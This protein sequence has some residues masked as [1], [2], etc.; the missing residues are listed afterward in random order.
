MIALLE[1]IA[2]CSPG[3]EQNVLGFEGTEKGYAAVKG[4]KIV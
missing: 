2:A 4:C 3:A 1:F